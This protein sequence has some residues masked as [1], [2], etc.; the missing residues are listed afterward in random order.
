MVLTKNNSEFNGQHYFQISD[1]AMGTRVA[2]YHTNNFMGNFEE[3][4]V[5]TC[6][7]SVFLCGVPTP[8]MSLI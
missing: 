2:P 8:T 5:Y 7:V 3:T 1:T 6:L 4:H